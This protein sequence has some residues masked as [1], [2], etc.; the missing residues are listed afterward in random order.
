MH[1]G[2]KIAPGKPDPRTCRAR[3]P[4]NG[5]NSFVMLSRTT[6]TATVWTDHRQRAPDGLVIQLYLLTS[7]DLADSCCHLSLC[8]PVWAL[9]ILRFVSMASVASY[10]TSAT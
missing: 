2:I 6:H 8:S 5:C 4:E 9:F 1:M 7:E 10:L 3:K